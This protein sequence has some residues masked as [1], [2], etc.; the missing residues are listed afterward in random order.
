MDQLREW[1]V[2]EVSKL[3]SYSMNTKPITKSNNEIADYLVKKDENFVE[4]YVVKLFGNTT[5][6]KTFVRDFLL[7]RHAIK[8]DSA[9]QKPPATV[10]APKGMMVLH[11]KKE[12]DFEAPKKKAPAKPKGNVQRNQKQQKKESDAMMQCDCFGTVHKALTN[13]LNCGRIVCE[14]E[15]YGPCK[16]C[17]CPVTKDAAVSELYANSK[18][19][20]KAIELRN[21]LIKYDKTAAKRTTIYDDQED[22]FTTSPW[23]S[24]EEIKAREE[25]AKQHELDRL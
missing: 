12:D 24:S 20:E 17:G 6:T 5:A 25:R 7:K 11:S 8:S 13:C 23:L 19:A 15:G 10:V 22:Y 18:D 4:S 16:F 14:K 1:T 2:K 9:Y 3:R 21:R